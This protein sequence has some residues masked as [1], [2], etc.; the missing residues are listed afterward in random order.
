MGGM[1]HHVILAISSKA[2][3]KWVTGQRQAEVMGLP[4]SW[5]IDKTGVYRSLGAHEGAV[6]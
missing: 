3:I 2:I 5:S 6:D 1:V 4:Q